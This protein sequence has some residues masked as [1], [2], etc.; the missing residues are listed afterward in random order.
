MSYIL[1]HRLD[2]YLNFDEIIFFDVFEDAN[3]EEV[4]DEPD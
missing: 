1:P 4:N 3:A 2:T